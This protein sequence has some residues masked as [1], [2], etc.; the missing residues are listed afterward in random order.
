MTRPAFR[1]LA[2]L[3]ALFVLLV[4]G[5]GGK[6]EAGGRRTDPT[7][8]IRWAVPAKP[9]PDTERRLVGGGPR[10]AVLIWQAGRRPPRDAVVFL[11]GWSAVPPSVYGPW[12][13]HLA[14]E[15]N[16]VVYPVYQDATTRPEAVGGNALA[17]I[18]AGLRAARARPD[19][20]A[21]LGHTTGGALAFYYAAN[22]AKHDLPPPRGVLAVY[23]ARDPGGGRVPIGALSGI[24]PRTAIEVV[25]GPGNP[26][27]GGRALARR[28]F[29]GP[30]QVPSGRRAL[31]RAGDPRPSGPVRAD[32]KAQRAF[33]LAADRLIARARRLRKG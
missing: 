31:R 19:R 13:R 30:D 27:V 21:A 14:L 5:C 32:A 16:T 17:G 24:A 20:V 1:R 23:P 10:A 33:W 15:G 26:V 22:A 8:S 12:L 28:L 11:H 4:P 9:I 7:A 18:A 6:S 25:D 2:P 3:L 29:R